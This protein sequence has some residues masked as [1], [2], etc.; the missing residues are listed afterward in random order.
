MLQVHLVFDAVEQ[1]YEGLVYEQHPVLGV[2]DDIGEVVLTQTWVQ[3]VQDQPRGRYAEVGFEVLVG[4]PGEGNDPVAL[5][6]PELPQ[7]YGELLGAPDEVSVGVTVEALV[8]AAG[9]DLFHAVEILGP[10][11]DRWQGQLVVL[12][13]SFHWSSL[14]LE[15][16]SFLFMADRRALVPWSLWRRFC[17]SR[18]INLLRVRCL[19]FG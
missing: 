13:Q 8:G 6:Q 3:G 7:S 2:V 19:A 18:L 15:A 1:F 17:L 5:L 10:L 11:E 14:R 16:F 12:D 9:N 4:V